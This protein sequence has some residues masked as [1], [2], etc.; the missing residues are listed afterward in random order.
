MLEY[1]LN[2]W[3]EIDQVIQQH[4]LGLWKFELSDE[5]W[6]VVQQLHNVLKVSLAFPMYGPCV[7]N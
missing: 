6:L 3:P 1:A 5:E 7:A 4:D 2:H